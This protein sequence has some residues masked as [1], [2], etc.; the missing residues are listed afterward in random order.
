MQAAYVFDIAFRVQPADASLA[1]DRFE[2]TLRLHAPKPGD[3]TEHIDWRF[4][5]TRLWNGDVSDEAPLRRAASEW[6]DVEVVEITFKELRTDQA[7]REALREAVAADLPQFN[8]ESVDESQRLSSANQKSEI[9][10]DA[11]K[12]IG[13][14]LGSSVH[15][16]PTE[17]V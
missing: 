5:Q 16:V 6:L 11:D 10:G 4:F 8:A 7:Y 17:A 12:A 2:S 14:H 9:S 3:E 13:Q 1:P 15:V